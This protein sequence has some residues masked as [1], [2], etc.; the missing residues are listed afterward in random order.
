MMTTGTETT[1]HTTVYD[2]LRQNLSAFTAPVPRNMPTND[3]YEDNR[4]F[5]NGLSD[6]AGAGAHVGFAAAVGGLATPSIAAKLDL[7]INDTLYGLKPGLPFGASL[8]CVEG[9]AGKEAPSCGP[10]TVVGP[11]ADGVMASMFWVPTSA[12][13]P[14]MPGYDYDP[15]YVNLDIIVKIKPLSP[16]RFRISPPHFGQRRHHRATSCDLHCGAPVTPVTTTAAAA[17]A[18]TT[19]TTTI[20]VP[21]PVVCIAVLDAER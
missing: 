1:T 2:R 6:E 21:H 18:T 4:I 14:K 17:V 3:G 16:P 8:Q 20:T 11:T 12:S 5:N 15:R 10:A 7:Y 13:E 9:E 19:T